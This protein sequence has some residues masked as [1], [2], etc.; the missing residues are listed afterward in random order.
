MTHRTDHRASA[1]HLDPRVL[2]DPLGSRVHP[3]YREREVPPELRAPPDP[4]GQPGSAAL[5]E[6]QDRR[7]PTGTMAL[8]DRRDDGENGAMISTIVEQ[9][10]CEENCTTK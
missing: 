7:A 10:Q 4:R 3:A 9:R 2:L 5:L 8:K 1:E 6:P